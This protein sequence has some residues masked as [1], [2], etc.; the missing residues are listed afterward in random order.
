MGPAWCSRTDSRQPWNGWWIWAQL[1]GGPYHHHHP[2][3]TWGHTPHPNPHPPH[4]PLCSEKAM[5]KLGTSSKPWKVKV[6]KSLSIRTKRTKTT[7]LHSFESLQ[8]LRQYQAGNTSSRKITK[9]K[10]LGP[11][12]GIGIFI[13]FSAYSTYRVYNSIEINVDMTQCIRSVGVRIASSCIR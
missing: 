9:V 5:K 4:H 10:Q 6:P 1:A 12:V 2:T 11:R 7:L 13:N 8:I 3:P